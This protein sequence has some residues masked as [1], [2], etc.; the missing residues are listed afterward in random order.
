MARSRLGIVFSVV[1]A[2]PAMAATGTF[3]A[4]PA[5]PCF[6]SG[7]TAYRLVTAGNASYTVRMDNSDATPDLRLQL[8]DDPAAA[9]FVL[10]DDGNNAAACSAAR[11]VKTIRVDAAAR[12]PDLTVALTQNSLDG[13]HKIYVRSGTFSDQ[14]AAALFAVIWQTARLREAR[15]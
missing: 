10:M 12:H 4:A 1:L 2:V 14:D 9:D 3:F 13:G 15:R 11:A 6:T 8:V 7:A 5:A